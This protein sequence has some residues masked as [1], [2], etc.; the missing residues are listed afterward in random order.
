MF[1]ILL[2]FLLLFSASV[3]AQGESTHMTPL[4]K[5]Y[6]KLMKDEGSQSEFY[7]IFLNSE[8]YIPTHT[9][10]DNDQRRRAGGD[11]SISPIFV[12][13]EGAQYLM[14]F[15]SK[16]RLSTWAKQEVGFVALP[17]HAVVEMM[18]SE[19]HWVLNV[20]TEYVKTFVPEEIQW[21]KQTVFDSKGKEASVSKGTK[22]LI[23]AP[24]TTP[25]GL[26]ESLLNTLAK[27]NEIKSAYLGQVHYVAEGEVPHLV[28][29]IDSG[30]LEK[31]TIEA[32]RNDLALATKGFLGE[33]EYIDIMFKSDSGVS[34]EVTNSVEPFY[35]SEK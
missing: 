24:A 27:N 16:E 14:L 25:K 23:G 19:F 3:F 13:F 21:L 7:N 1:K 6:V 32:I 34:E 11:E 22:V 2:T 17:G 5:A 35:V 28:L 30:D 20:G 9:I 15:D 33:S 10:P 12:E 18:N 29:V 8:L 26:T 4:D 31:S